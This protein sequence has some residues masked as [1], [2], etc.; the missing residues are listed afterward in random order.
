MTLSQWQEDT[1]N[2]GGDRHAIIVQPGS[3]NFWETWQAKRIGTNWQASTGARFNLNS[4][5]LRP[6]GWTSGDAAGLPMF[7][8]IVRYDECQRG[9]VDHALRIGV[10]KS[11]REYIYPATHFASS[12]S[13]SSTTY[14]AMGQR[15]R[16]KASFV[17]PDNWTIEEKAVL[18][19]LKK[20]GA[21]V[22]DN[23]NFFSVSVCPDDRFASSAFD[24]LSTIGISNFE[25]IQTTGLTEGPRLPGAPSV[26]A[27][28]DQFLE[29]PTNISLS[30]SVTD[31]SGR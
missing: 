2:V 10:A 16:L 23:G 15:V 12:I 30:G 1:N 14:P 20:Y 17:I 28:V 11:R 25:V 27:G 9:M 31:P 13:A 5:G 21:L 29:W 26:N 19:A 22:A 6:A 18:R 7:P 3:G 24:H 8:A 4:N